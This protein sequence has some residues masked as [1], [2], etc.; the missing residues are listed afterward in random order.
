M[1]D[2]LDALPDDVVR[3]RPVL[4]VHYAG[5]LLIGGQVD[6]AEAR[7][8][9]AER[10]LSANQEVPEGPRGQTAGMVV[11]D[12]GEFRRLPGAIA[13]YRAARDRIVGDAAGS[14][15]HARRAVGL[16]GG[17]DHLE[18]GAATGLLALGYWSSGELEAAHRSWG[19]AVTSLEK[20][21]HVS[22]VLGCM[23][24]MADIR[25]AQGRLR[26]AMGTY[27][28]GLR[29]ASEQ[30]ADV[31]RGSADMHVGIGEV[32]LERGDL[33][34]A[35]R[36]LLRS[37]ELGELAGLEQNPYRW[38]VAMARLREAEGDLDAALDLLDEAGGV[39]AG[40]YF[41]D[42]RPI[43]AL[44]ARTWIS[45][46]RMDEADEWAREHG[47]TA[48]DDPS[49]LREFE[50]LTL[51]RLLIVHESSRDA[52]TFLERLKSAAEH[53][54]R[55]RS[56]IEILLLQ[57]LA[58]LALGDMPAALVRLRR[59]MILAEPEGHVQLFVGEGARAAA[60]IEAAARHGIAPDYCRR[61]LASP[62]PAE[63]TMRPRQALVEPLSSREV[64]VLRLLATE[65]DG[66][67]IAREL[68]VSLS[69]IRSHTKSI[70]AKLG[71]HSRRAAVR[72]ATE[73]DL[74]R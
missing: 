19:E 41:P 71:V 73:L 35:T 59:A 10:W 56:I 62:V 45:Q 1:R 33:Q 69:T 22:D 48:G 66:P 24:A 8:Q 27:E 55:T 74:L 31:V 51:A 42:L 68:V 52:V 64:D 17:D 14:I 23:I 72:R 15:A 26:E 49:Y 70:Y 6:G 57:A 30:G 9:D 4:S 29:R 34:A 39:Y 11:V 65:I 5:A 61:L 40:G 46:G 25:I 60:L 36:H 53:G 3:M 67:G 21:G 58:H 44:K 2:W 63:V 54:E 50:H 37:S 12:E 47:V 32:F 28:R 16:I 18:R 13:I 7:L 43:A 38:R 20:A